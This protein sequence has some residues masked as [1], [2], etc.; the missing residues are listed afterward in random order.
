[1]YRIRIGGKYADSWQGVHR[2]RI[3]MDA[4]GPSGYIGDIDYFKFSAVE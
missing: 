2:I 4:V 3:V 1:M